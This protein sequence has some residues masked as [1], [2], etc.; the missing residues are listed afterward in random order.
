M[1]IWIRAKFDEL[2]LTL[3]LIFATIGLVLA[4]LQIWTASLLY[5]LAA[6]VTFFAA[7]IWKEPS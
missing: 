7:V 5:L 2:V 4:I 3:V 6:A 1:L